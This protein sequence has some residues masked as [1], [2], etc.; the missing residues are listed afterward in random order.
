[1]SASQK[2]AKLAILFADISG[3]TALYDQLGDVQALL[4]VTKCLDIMIAELAPLQGVL[5]KTIGDEIMC[6]FPTPIAALEAA[7]AMQSAIKRERPG[8]DIYINVRIGFH[9][10]EVVQEGNDVFGEAVNVAARVTSITRARQILTT[11]AVALAL[12]K[13]YAEIVQKISRVEFRGKEAA[14]DIFQVNWAPGDVETTRIISQQFNDTPATPQ[15]LVLNYRGQTATINEQHK[16]IV[17]G[18]GD[19]CDLVIRG[20]YASRQHVRIE[21]SF[22]KF[23]I[24]D[25]SANGTFIRFGDNHVV[26]LVRQETMLHDKGTISL[27]Q[28]FNENP[29]EVIEYQ[30]Q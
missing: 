4:L 22:G 8:G 29:A 2:K 30:L 26:H 5:I 6:T 19:T 10:G 7:C 18:R 17:L 27:G 23:V 13:E 15:Q 21:L 16:S 28:P 24:A 3:S 9:Y 20:P 25:H 12:P 11:Q 14:L 1:M